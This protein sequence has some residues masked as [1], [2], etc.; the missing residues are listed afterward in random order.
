MSCLNR[1]GMLL[2][3]HSKVDL[4]RLMN[5]VFDDLK[6]A[7]LSFSHFSSCSYISLWILLMLR[8]AKSSTTYAV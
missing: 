6:T 7:P 8:L 5:A 1:S 3:R 4:V 2:S